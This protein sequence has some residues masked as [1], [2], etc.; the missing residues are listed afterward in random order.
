MKERSARIA[1]T[2]RVKGCPL[3]AS[4]IFSKR[5][6]YYCET[7]PNFNWWFFEGGVI[8]RFVGPRA[9]DGDEQKTRCL[10]PDNNGLVHSGQ[11]TQS[12]AHGNF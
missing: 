11:S 6:S 10:P 5:F 2:D 3:P 8:Q 7:V 9:G 4:L 12:R 1:A